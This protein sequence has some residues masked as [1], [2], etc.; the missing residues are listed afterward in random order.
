MTSLFIVQ[1]WATSV[2]DNYST[3]N[4][5]DKDVFSNPVATKDLS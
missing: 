1:K 5:V 2:V 3:D 4:D